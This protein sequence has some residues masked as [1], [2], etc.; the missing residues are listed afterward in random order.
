MFHPSFHVSI[1]SFINI[2]VCEREGERVRYKEREREE[3]KIV[4]IL[5]LGVI[6]EDL[7]T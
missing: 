5:T 4:Y 1:R 7:Y 2:W 3:R 6:N